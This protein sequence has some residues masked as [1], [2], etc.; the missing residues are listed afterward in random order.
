MLDTNA[1]SDFLKDPTGPVATRVRA[2]RTAVTISVIVAAELRF[3]AAKRGSARLNAAIDQLLDMLVVE[4]LG[5]PVAS[6]YGALR[7]HLELSGRTVDANDLLIAAHALALGRRLV[8]RDKAFSQ[9]PDL[10]VEDWSV[11][12]LSS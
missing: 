2:Q 11:P 4:P 9:V 1:V 8:T 12:G 10:V 6:I 5:L 3:G 7:A